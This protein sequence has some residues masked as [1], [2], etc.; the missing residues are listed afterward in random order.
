[1][2]EA[3]RDRAPVLPPTALV[4][5]GDPDAIDRIGWRRRPF[6]DAAHAMLSAPWWKTM[7]VFLVFY[8]FVNTLFA[9]A[10]MVLG[11][12][13]N[14]RPGS[15]SDA[16]FFSI[17]TLATIGY[18]KMAP[19]G[20]AAHIL[21]AIEA[22]LGVLS[23]TMLTGLMFAKFARPTARVMFSRNAV[24]G[25]YDGKP[26]LMFRMAN[27]RA[28]Q[29]VEANLKVIVVRDETTR[30]GMSLRRM[31]DVKLTRANSALFALT[32][33]AIH[34]ITPDSPLHGATPESLIEQGAQIVIALIGFDDTFSQT[35]HARHAY[36]P[37][38]IVFN[39]RLADIITV[40]PRGRRQVD[41][42]RFHDVVR[43]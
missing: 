21:V 8:L 20:T 33:M 1:M 10:Y 25:T 6:S 29:I 36:L 18:G 35:I 28:N 30:E 31:H 11:G 16:F 14:A 32:W 13:E 37:E 39:A 17:Q 7:V 26:A 9:V 23:V 34:E 2:A 15:F 12:V 3:V 19:I 41:Y 22:L 43:S 40:S 27:E 38:E 5:W 24:I 4:R 42:T